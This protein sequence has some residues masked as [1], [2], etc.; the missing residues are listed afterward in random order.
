MCGCVD[1]CVQGDSGSCPVPRF[2]DGAERHPRSSVA[3][4]LAKSHALVTSALAPLVGKA[5]AFLESL[6]GYKYAVIRHSCLLLP[7]ATVPVH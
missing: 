5:N 2:A 7:Q 4:E 1:V 6:A 3:E